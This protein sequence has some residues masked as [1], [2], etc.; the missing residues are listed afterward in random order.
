MGSSN[1]P[2]S[3]FANQK[4]RFLRTK[5]RGVRTLSNAAPCFPKKIS[6]E[7]FEDY[8]HPTHPFSNLGIYLWMLRVLETAMAPDHVTPIGNVATWREFVDRN[9]FI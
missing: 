8:H 9:D 1:R 7:Y 4:K 2:K 5:N 6:F 3:S